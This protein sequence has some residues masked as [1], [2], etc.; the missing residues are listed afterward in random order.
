M[1]FLSGLGAFSSTLALLMLV[2]FSAVALPET[3]VGGTKGNDRGSP[4]YPNWI[5]PTTAAA[6]NC[7]ALCSALL[8]LGTTVSGVMT[9]ATSSLQAREESGPFFTL[10]VLAAA[11]AAGRRCR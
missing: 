4:S 6:T 7:A 10:T 3:R 11:P 8:G 2:A 1:K 9:T 5:L